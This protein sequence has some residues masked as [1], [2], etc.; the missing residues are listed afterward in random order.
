MFSIIIPCYNHAHFLSDCLDSILQQRIQGIEIVLVDDGSEDDTRILCLSYQ[1]KF[2]DISYVYQSNQGLSVARNAGMKQSSGEYLLFLDADDWLEPTFLETLK[3]T[4]AKAPSFDLC[5][6][7]YGYWDQPGGRCFHRHSPSPSFEVYPDVLTQNLGPCHSIL[8]R[9]DFANSLGGFDPLLKSCEDWDFW[10]RAG[11]LG[12]RMHSIPDVLVAYRYVEDSMSRHPRRMY[13]ALSEVSQ[14]AAKVD[15]RLPS[16][17]PYNLPYG[18]DFSLVQRNHLI[19][20]LGLMIYQG[21]P[22][23]AAQWYLDEQKKWGWPVTNSD[24][25]R[26]SSYLSWAYFFDPKEI[27]ELLSTT[28]PR[29]HSFFK[30][31]AYS[32]AEA[33][34]LVRRVFSPQFKRRNHIRYGRVLGALSNKLGWY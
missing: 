29:L 17:A 32:K 16:D 13:H 24:W 28:A 7:G 30:L 22:E 18:L 31:L 26:L 4:L 15:P 10:I 2:P 20:L 21:K 3:L 23:E 1:A 19:P 25:S 27:S 11:K 9:S 5:R 12:A 33:E 8:I 14:R 6:V 34:L